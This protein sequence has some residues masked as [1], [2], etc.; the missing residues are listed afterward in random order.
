M[1]FSTLRSLKTE[2]R[3][4]KPVRATTAD[5]DLQARASAQE[6]VR[7]VV[8]HQAIPG[9]SLARERHHFG[10]HRGEP[11][12]PGLF[13]TDRGRCLRAEVEILTESLILAQDERWR[14]A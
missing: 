9:A 14:R 3:T 7:A 10:N 8:V 5:G 4:K 11:L 1:A 6:D 12:C 2:Q 13:I